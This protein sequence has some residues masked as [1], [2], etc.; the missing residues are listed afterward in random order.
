MSDWEDYAASV[1]EREPSAEAK[2]ELEE[3]A[4]DLLSANEDVAR[5]ELKLKDA[6]KKA[7]NISEQLIPAKFQDMG[8][9]YNSV[10]SLGGVQITIK[11]KLFAAPKAE[12]RDEAYDWLEERGYSGLIKRKAVFHIGLGREEE[13][14]EW[15]ESVTD[16]IGT[17][18]RKVEPMTLK[19]FVSDKIKGGEEIPMDLFGAWMKTET[20]IK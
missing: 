18:E 10:I 13:A 7:S 3:L 11:E 5:L 12:R 8:L 20:V 1:E 6:K 4:R 19:K 2:S 15:I 14:K 17:F 16:Y 9:D